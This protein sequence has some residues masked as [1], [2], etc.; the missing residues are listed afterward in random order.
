MCFFLKRQ[1]LYDK[2]K[3]VDNSRLV[4]NIHLFKI[5]SQLYIIYHYS[6]FSF[7]N[8]FV[9]IIAKMLVK[10]IVSIFHNVNFDRIKHINWTML[11]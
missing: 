2:I 8:N 1:L 10:K 7:S 4:G 5:I 3:N 6:I 11:Y 9:E